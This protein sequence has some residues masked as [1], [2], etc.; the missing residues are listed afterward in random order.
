MKA[1]KGSREQEVDQ[2]MVGDSRE[3]MVEARNSTLHV[4]GAS[5]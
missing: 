3:Q 4:L 1:R 2:V 5:N